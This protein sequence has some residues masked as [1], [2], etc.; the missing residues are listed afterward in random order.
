MKPLKTMM[1]T[2]CTAAVAVGLGLAGA[3]PAQAGT[4]VYYGPYSASGSCN[5]D[6]TELLNSGYLK[7][8]VGCYRTVEGYWHFYGWR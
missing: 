3:V 2:A 4:E 7:S 5:A 6:R 8:A 1:I